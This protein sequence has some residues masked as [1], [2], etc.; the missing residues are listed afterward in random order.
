MRKLI[1]ILAV[2]GCANTNNEPQYV[3]C[4]P[5]GAAP[6]DTCHLEAGTMDVPEAKGSL[7]VPVKP[8]SMWR[9]RD[10]AVRDDLQMTMPDGVEVPVLRLEHYDLEV[11]WSV[12]NLDAMKSQFRVDLNGANEQFTYDPSMIILNPGDDEAPP[13]PPLAGNIPIDIEGN[14]TVSGVFREDQVLEA[15][16][17]LDQITRG[18][19]NPFAATLTVSTNADMFQPLTPAVYDPDTG[20][21][22]PG[23][24]SGPAIPRAAFR[25]L[26]RVDVVFKPG[27]H[28][29]LD[30]T[31]RVREH[32]EIIHEMGLAA[33]AGELQIL[34]P[35]PYLP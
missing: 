16:V 31:L 9:A 21:V 15:A 8:E 14:A 29:T 22:T 10:R 26:V 11:E 7:H 27:A 6:M 12:T 1:F 20:E 13:T 34:D 2:S 32:T 23:T 4:V 5:D 3:G 28:M 30:Y 33:P 25:Q 19:V 17:D 35:A 24:P 18:N